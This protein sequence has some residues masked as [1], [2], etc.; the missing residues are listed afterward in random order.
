MAELGR[1]ALVIALGLE[2]WAVGAGGYAAWRGRRRLAASARNAL[3]PAFGAILVAALVLEAALLRRDFSFPYVAQHTSRELGQGYAA[4]SF[5]SGQE[6]SLLLWLLILTGFSAAAPLLAR[7]PV[8]AL[9]PWVVPV[10][11]AVGTF[12]SFM[13]VFVASPFG[14]QPPPADGAGMNPSLQNPYML[15]PPPM[16]Y[17]GYVGL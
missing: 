1:G 11:A 12:F 14:T 13:L 2:L 6:G 7:R 8:R 5:W 15:A 10:L 17:L 9:L 3:L 16:L 4:A